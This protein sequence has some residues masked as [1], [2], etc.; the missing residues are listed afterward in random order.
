MHTA[1]RDVGLVVSVECS[2]SSLPLARLLELQFQTAKGNGVSFFPLHVGDHIICP[3]WML[4]YRDLVRLL[5]IG[6]FHGI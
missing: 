2:Q 4:L 1:K 3:R 6:E 5:Y